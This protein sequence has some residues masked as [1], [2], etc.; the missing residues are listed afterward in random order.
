[1]N[2]QIFRMLAL[3][4]YYFSG[5]VGGRCITAPAGAPDDYYWLTRHGAERTTV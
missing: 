1:M 3:L 2:K 5:Q 4:G